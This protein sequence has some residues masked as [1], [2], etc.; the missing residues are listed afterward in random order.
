MDQEK[1]QVGLRIKEARD[2]ADM[3]QNEL[4][5]LL[6][7]TGGAV[8]QWELGITI[9]RAQTINRLSEIFGVSPD[10]LLG[11]EGRKT[12]A[13]RTDPEE[14]VLQLF[15]KLSDVEQEIVIRQ[16]EGLTRSK[17]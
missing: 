13:V 8:G 12:D 10:W 15:G 3:S 2:R 11:K 7:I 16:L 14:H 1:V 6:D 4:A 17:R 9:P 5:R